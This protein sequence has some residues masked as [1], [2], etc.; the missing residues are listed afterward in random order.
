MPI[1]ALWYT[2]CP[3]PTAFSQAI[4]LGWIDKEF[5]HDQIRVASLLSS[6]IRSTRESHFAHT[7][8]NSFR[9][10]GN[11][12]PLWA[13]SE[14]NDVRLI[15]LS[16]TEENQVVLT[17]PDSAI[18]T[19]SDL[20]GRKLAVPRRLHDTIDFWRATV[21][22]GYQAAL[23]TV[24]LTEHDV[25]FV[26]IPVERAW[27]DDAP[28]STAQRGS[29]GGAASTRAFQREEAVAL[30]TGRV[31]AIFSAHAHAADIKAFLGARVAIDLRENT[32]RSLRINNCTPL[33]LTAS[34]TLIEQRPDLV[35]RWLAKVIEA[36]HW[37][38]AHR[39]ETFRIVAAESGVAEETAHAAFGE[40]LPDQLV[41]DL[42]DENV[43]ALISQKDFLFAQG[44]IKRDFDIEQ[45][46][47]RRPLA[48]AIQ[49][50]SSNRAIQ[51][52]SPERS[53]SRTDLS[54]SPAGK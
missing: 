36:G 1:D 9:H 11:I 32:N 19:A 10:G 42:S 50:I 23:S 54:L 38:K 6:P 22:R 46:I 30:L 17:L 7:Q 53:I 48:E 41:P 13:F 29:L 16:W 4:R 40:K 18:R 26:E 39:D 27:L 12:P 15:A 47:V 24:G 33:A 28:K 45:F 25:Q 52:Y 14:G 51:D 2:R 34:G 5:A 8:P 43:R 49:I 3:V 37:A 21:L 31:D 20:K 44:F 35:A